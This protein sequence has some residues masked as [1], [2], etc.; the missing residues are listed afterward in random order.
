MFKVAL[1]TSQ[2]YGTWGDLKQLRQ[3]GSYV[4]LMSYSFYRSCFMDNEDDPVVVGQEW[5]S[6]YSGRI[7]KV[8]AVNCRCGCVNLLG[9]FNSLTQAALR[10]HFTLVRANC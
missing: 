1:V 3:L 4:T 8:D 10:E 5:L 2:P 7:L 9:C 6:I